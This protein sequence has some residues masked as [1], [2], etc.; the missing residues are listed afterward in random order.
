MKATSPS[1]PAE[2]LLQHYIPPAGYDEACKPDGTLRPGWQV[3]MTHL[4][5]LGT[6]RVAGL[7]QQA[8][9][10]LLENG[11]T[12]N[13]SQTGAENQRTWELDLLPLIIDQAEWLQ[14]ERGL[15]QRHQV[16]EKLL[17]DIYGK[18]EVLRS[19]VLPPTL[20]FSHPGGYL[21][22]CRGLP[23]PRGTSLPWLAVDLLRTRQGHFQVLGD[24]LQVPTGAGFALEKRQ[25]LFRLLRHPLNDN[26]V[27]L[28]LPFFSALRNNL[29]ETSPNIKEDPQIVLLTPGPQD[30][31]YFEHAFLANYLGLTLVQGEELTVRGGRLF[32][33]TL[34]GLHPVDVVLRMLKDTQCDPLELGEDEFLGVA[35]L[36]QAVLGQRVTLLNHPG[37]AILENQAL[38]GYYHDICRHFLN[39]EPQLP[40]TPTWW[41]GD[42][43]A[44]E[45]VLD[46]L[47]HLVIREHAKPLQH[48]GR[49]S[50]AERQ[51]LRQRLVA[52]P[53]DFIAQSPVQPS[54]IPVMTPSGVQPGEVLLRTFATANKQG[55]EVMP[56]GVARVLSESEL[57]STWIGQSCIT[58][59]VWILSH[60]ASAVRT[61]RLPL[62]RLSEP[63]FFA[64]ELSS[65]TAEN[66]FWIGRY[67]ERTEN[68]LRLL[69]VLLLLPRPASMERQQEDEQAALRLLYRALTLVTGTQPGFVG[70]GAAA[71]FLDTEKELLTLIRA[72]DCPGGIHSSIH[73]LA[74][75]A[76]RVRERLSNDTWRVLN[77]I[78]GLYQQLCNQK[79]TA[80]MVGEIERL[81][82]TFAAL[83]GLA[84]ES[85][86]RALGWRFLDMGRRV[87][88]A[89]F[90]LELLQATLVPALDQEG[91]RILLDALLNISDS[92]ITYRRR[93]RTHFAV[94]PFLELILLDETNPRGL[95]SQ[96]SSIETHVAALPRRGNTPPYRTPSG[97]IVLETV[98]EL[99]MAE[100]DLL[101]IVGENGERRNLSELLGRVQMLLPLFSMELAH[102]F[103]QHSHS[104]VLRG[105]RM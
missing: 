9:Q 58:K 101:G 66:L 104:H 81:I 57:P 29:L 85:M 63:S 22:S 83:A 19:G 55:V 70:E 79:S 47:E 100:T 27:R 42:P 105:G 65:R 24:L 49:L 80:E 8:G 60:T 51:Q 17:E 94:K 67:A 77:Q 54:T 31:L 36:V 62:D 26:N 20:I 98:N 87:E 68:N 48:G 12:Y 2:D 21:R 59:D 30:K 14:V 11:I 50:A 96:L 89:I 45:R 93:Y 37:A 61:N 99:R 97:R 28:L 75:A 5:R 4:N 35:G 16:L 78:L 91:E 71:R 56:G 76:H 25:I 23:L 64:G 90:V 86:T 69:R 3:L 13:L 74:L 52:R 41:C 88:R 103:F 15:Q 32:I 72:V 73:A 92:S 44:L 95:A 82:T 46:E 39:E 53:Q 84:G 102:A 38:L 34:D 1:S 10:L 33:K 6:T 18:Q 43:I 40:V 7:R